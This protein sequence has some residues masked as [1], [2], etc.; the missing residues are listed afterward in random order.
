MDG[1]QATDEEIKEIFGED[2]S[3]KPPISESVS[4]SAVTGEQVD[5][6]SPRV[7][8][9]NELLSHAFYIITSIGESEDE[10]ISLQDWEEN[11]QDIH[12]GK[13]S[14]K[15]AFMNV[16]EQGE[17]IM[18]LLAASGVCIE[19]AKEIY[20]EVWSF[21]ESN[22][23]DVKQ[24]NKAI[25]SARKE[26]VD[27]RRPSGV[28][29]REQDLENRREDL[30]HEAE[31]ILG[32]LEREILNRFKGKDKKYLAE[33]VETMPERVNSEITNQNERKKLVSQA[34]RYAERR[35]EQIRKKNTE[36]MRW[37]QD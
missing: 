25:H 21:I 20:K 9:A 31:S 16:V 7:K 15:K 2:D 29:E 13:K 4:G 6:I 33:R 3:D 12:R 8:R 28:I 22:E 11:L 34:E 14:G 24:L 26:D 23:I 1:D 5:Y 18:E 17:E 19:S 32:P 37:M 27:I 30:M 10:V 35:E 36:S